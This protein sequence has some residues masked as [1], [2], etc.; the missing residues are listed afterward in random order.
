MASAS[1]GRCVKSRPVAGTRRVGALG[2]MR[3][4]V[5]PV[6]GPLHLEPNMPAPDMPRA[7][8]AESPASTAQECQQRAAECL[9]LVRDALDPT[10]KALLLEMA[11][12]WIRLAEQ[13]TAKGED[14]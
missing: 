8:F 7:F 13:H 3:P 5:S 2:R 1:H 6:N 12:A 9:R 10:N 11:Q 14:S 4:R